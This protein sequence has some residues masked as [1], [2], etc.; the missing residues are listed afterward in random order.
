MKRIIAA[1]FILCAFLLIGF[2]GTN[3]SRQDITFNNQVVRIFQR[4]CQVC[5]H[6]GDIA[7]FSLM[8][9]SEARPWARAIKEKVILRQMPP[10]KPVSGCGEFEGARRLSEEEIQ[11][12]SQ[13]VDAG[14]PEGNPA[15]LPE[16]LSFP[17]NW[18]LGQPDVVLQPD[19]DYTVRPGNDIYRC[20]SIPT[21][22]RGDRY[23]S[24]V[25]IR[26]GNRNIVHHVI[27]YLDT[28]GVSKTLDD[29]DPGP[30]YTCFGGPGFQT[31]GTLGGWAPGVRAAFLNDGIAWALPK[32]ARVVAQVHYHPRDGEETDRTQI[33][34]YYA[35]KPVRKE[36]QVV[37]MVNTSFVI[38]PGDARHRVTA[39]FIVPPT[40][41]AHAIAIAPHMHL[42]GREMKVEAR[43]PDGSTRCLVNIDDWNFN[44]QGVYNYKVPVPL[45]QLTLLSL[46]AYFDNSE[47]NPLNPNSPPKTV[48]WGEQT[49]DEMCIAFVEYT[50]DGQ[51]IEPSQPRI[52]DVRIEG[53]KLIVDGSGFLP[54]A[55][56]EIDGNRLS[57]SK[58]HKKKKKSAKQL[59][60]ANDWKQFITPGR[61]AI[62]TVLN[63][64]GVRAEGKAIT[65]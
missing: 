12:I 23:L 36:V 7:P 33:G 20:F 19:E 30:G 14:S 41:N 6:P 9:Y 53:D 31:T 47:N 50:L 37:P 3:A 57:D 42:L 4:N 10:W 38:Q 25:D 63:T 5:H 52:S 64:D 24:A 43:Y 62:I 1:L 51:N 65:P 11:T 48:R 18:T 59:T 45:P 55:D 28:T 44:W 35:R 60:S 29:Q 40:L 13:W 2:G 15:D 8:T 21:S 49:T 32:D 58:N 54:G 39:Q 56:I 27:L 17:N 61:Q 22:L 34:L 16:P 46:T 26:P